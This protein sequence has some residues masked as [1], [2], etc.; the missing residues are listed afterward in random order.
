MKRTLFFAVIILLLVPGL[1]I[2]QADLTG[3][4]TGVVQDPVEAVIPGASVK[5]THLGTGAVYEVT[6]NAAGRFVIAGARLG[7]YDVT[8]E[9]QG[10]RRAVIT[11]VHVEVGQT[12]S[13]NIDLQLGAVTEEVVV[14]A[15]DAQQ[16]INTVDAELSTVVD[17]KRVLE[18]PLNG[19]NATELAL[20]QAGVYYETTATGEGTKFIV[21]GQRH[22]AINITLD[23]LDTQDN[24][25]RASS[26]M[27][28]Q[29]LIAI[30]AENVQEFKVA[31]GNTTAE[32]SRGG[33]QISAVTRSGS[34]EWHGSLFWFHRNDV[35]SANDFFNNTVGQETPKRLRH[36]FGG[37]VGGPI[38][39][40]KTFFFFGYQQTRDTRGIPV[41]RTVWS[42]EAR[43][44]IFQF[45]DGAETNPANV[46]SGSFPVF[47]I[48]L[49]RCDPAADSA[50]EC[51]DDR[52]DIVDPIVALDSTF[53]YDRI[54]L[55][56]LI[57][58]SVIPAMPLP[59]DPTR[60]DGLNTQGFRFNSVSKTFE[61]LP[62]F[63]LDHVF[64]PKHSF[65]ATFNYTDRNIIGDFVNERE[66]IWPTLD[67]LGFRTT[68]SKAF[69]AG[70][71]S[72]F[73]PTMVNEFRWGVTAGE[74]AFIR[75]Q[76]FNTPFTLD[77]DDISDPYNPG[78]ASGTARDNETWH[79]RDTVS[80]VRGK[81]QFK[82]GGEWRHR[83][84]DNRNFLGTE[85]WGEIDFNDSDFRP[86]WRESNILPRAENIATGV[87]GGAGNMT[88]D[89][90]NDAEELNNN[91]I[92]AIGDI[93]ER[94]NVVDLNSGF[95]PLAGEIRRWESEELD[96]FFN[97]TWQ[98]S[99]R[100][101]LTMGLRWEYASIPDENSG[102]ILL[103]EFGEDAV[104][105]VSGPEGF[106]NPGTLAGTSCPS[107]GALPI[108][109]TEA[110]VLALID[111]CSIRN[112]LAGGSTG[113][114]LWD[115]DYNNFGPVLSLAWDPWGDG[116]SAVR[117]G[118]RIS[119][120]QD[121]FAMVED[122]VDDNEGLKS[123]A[124][125]EPS[126]SG[127]P[128]QNVDPTVDLAALLRNIT[129]APLPPVPVFSLPTGPPETTFLRTSSADFR[130]FVEDLE[131]PY[132]QE[133]NLSVSRE[134]WGHTAFEVRYVGNRGLKLRR[135]KDF[136]E[137]NV[138]AFDPVTG[139]TFVEA[140]EIAQ[141]NLACNRVED[142]VDDFSERGNVCNVSNPLM[143]DLIAGDP[144]RLDDRGDLIDALDRNGTA[145]FVGEFL[146]SETSRPDSGLSTGERMPGGSF[147]GQVLNGRFP[148]NF[149]NA[150]PFVASS[151]RMS[152]DGFSTYHGVEIEARR[153]LSQGLMFQANY[154][155]GK[156]LSDYDGDSNTLVNDTRASSI[157]NPRYSTSLIMP[158]HQFNANWVYELPIG[159]G[160]AFELQSTAARKLLEGWQFGGIF[161][162]RSG[163]PISITSNVGTFH[164]EAISDDNTVNLA[165]G[166]TNDDLRGL[167]GLQT[168]GGGLFWIDPNTS[169]IAVSPSGTCTDPAGDSALFQCPN[170]GELG[171]LGHTPIFG[172]S[173]FTLDF[174]LSKRT[175]ITETVDI[176]FRWEVFNATNRP[177]FNIPALDIFSENFGRIQ[178]MVTEP[179][180]MQFALK[181]N[182]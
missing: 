49:L 48:D 93:E 159:S 114:K 177:N 146:Y 112:V 80:W 19:R 23:G 140:F 77:F 54:T 70:L 21:H 139:M 83:Y 45:L 141:A 122:H 85:E 105:G 119:Y 121:A 5:A 174:N 155:F 176:E 138:H 97:D 148:I 103:P 66:T 3:R 164:R 26:I 14:T 101:T 64:S 75:Q 145:D 86:G 126:D 154:T 69:G 169:R 158:L 131:T 56:P 115:D 109:P 7:T 142:G 128:C 81:H 182:F 162:L 28:N 171:T 124:N 95:V 25:N 123:F 143:N 16:I 153:R 38:I 137:V 106:F 1:A 33:A 13:L 8:V 12:A 151:R 43:Q 36:Q 111:E 37:R 117:A 30:S 82:F 67:P 73:T 42:A 165:Q 178:S 161:R 15:D 35:F 65:Y 87:I 20:L 102:L 144:S 107:L 118:Y 50:D 96:F 17:D 166:L 149:F 11:G 88:S 51:L 108:T 41:N 40:D 57:G 34:N 147:W 150:N 46:A 61:H 98:V 53:G 152:N 168:I 156:G 116:K 2:A 6:T 22:V 72:T 157:I 135:A 18:L 125:C 63:R 163:R 39:K 91:L 60:G 59:N 173:R 179:R 133:W 62:A 92:G 134:F 4:I 172:P 170:P 79:L 74:N 132:Y 27:V 120:F 52:W 94:F 24:F 78:G 100:L 31:T 55:D 10:F 89:E 130:T 180:L 71:T 136:N 9:A 127:R 129:A 58:G 90:V 47:A 84:V 76:P 181:I 29:P 32:Y 44:G 68:L 167:T 113:I 110:N 104:W 175:Q 99:P 160:R